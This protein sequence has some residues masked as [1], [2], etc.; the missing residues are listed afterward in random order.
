MAIQAVLVSYCE[1]A[2]YWLLIGS[3]HFQTEMSCCIQIDC[4]DGSA[5][6]AYD[7]TA[8][9]LFKSMTLH[10]NVT[11][12]VNI[13]LHLS[14]IHVWYGSFSFT[15]EFENFWRIYLLISTV[16]VYSIHEGVYDHQLISP[17]IICWK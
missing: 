1:K 14:Y 5:I 11:R 3:A 12:Y 7:N 10:D 9:V 16:H 6:A 8:S 13:Y 15:G 2:N 4:I 17:Y